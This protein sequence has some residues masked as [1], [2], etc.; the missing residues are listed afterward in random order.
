[1]NELRKEEG[2]SNNF[3]SNTNDLVGMYSQPI[4]KYFNE[5]STKVLLKPLQNR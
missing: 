3:A 5:D 2:M 4:V 1:L